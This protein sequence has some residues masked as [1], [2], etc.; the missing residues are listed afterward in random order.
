MNQNKRKFKRYFLA[1]IMLIL[2]VYTTL[3][4]KDTVDSLH[5]EESLPLINV[6]VGYTNP[7]VKRTGYTWQFGAREIRSPFLHPPDVTLISLEAPTDT[8]IVINFS[9]D[10][11][12]LNVSYAEEQTALSSQNYSPFIGIPKTPTQEGVYIYKIDV[13][14]EDGN[15]LYYFALDVTNDPYS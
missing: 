6:S 2:S 11:E 14:F 10:Y 8:P 4:I 15:V 7:Q 3:F 12:V 9:S 5:P 13:K 1:I